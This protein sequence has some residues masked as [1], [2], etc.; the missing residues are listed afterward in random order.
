[1]LDIGAE[2]AGVYLAVPSITAAGAE[3]VTAEALSAVALLTGTDLVAA[4]ETEDAWKS[5]GP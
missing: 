2:E 5:A 1:M 3:G 4:Y